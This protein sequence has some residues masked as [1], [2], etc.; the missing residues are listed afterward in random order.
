MWS[1]FKFLSCPLG[2][3]SDPNAFLMNN[4]C[5]VEVYLLPRHQIY[6]ALFAVDHLSTEVIQDK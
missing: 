4:F 6:A 3:M 2:H 5:V 1:E